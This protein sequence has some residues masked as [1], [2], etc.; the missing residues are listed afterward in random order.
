MIFPQVDAL[1]LMQPTQTAETGKG[2]TPWQ[3]ASAKARYD[4]SDHQRELVEPLGQH[5][6]NY[7][8]FLLVNCKIVR[9]Y[10]LLEPWGTILMATARA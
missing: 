4:R 10:A 1:V 7:F 9:T 6:S 2:R 5:F 8:H 3:N